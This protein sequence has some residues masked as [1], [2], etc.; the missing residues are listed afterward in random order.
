MWHVWCGGGTRE[1]GGL[2]CFFP[3]LC[4]RMQATSRPLCGEEAR[5]YKCI[6]PGKSKPVFFFGKAPMDIP[7][8][9]VVVFTAL[10][11]N[12]K[13]RERERERVE[14]ERERERGTSL[15]L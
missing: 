1:V 11:H 14:R 7:T 3:L 15:S 13:K 12:W 5:F 6:Q 4:S 9:P 8:F 10:L 2:P